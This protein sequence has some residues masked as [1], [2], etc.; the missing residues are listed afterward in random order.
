MESLKMVLKEP[1]CRQCRCREWTCRHSGGGRGWEERR[2]GVNACT[3]SGV[4]W[5]GGEQLLQSTGASLPLCDEMGEQE[6]REGNVCT[7]IAD[8]YCCMA[9][10]NTAL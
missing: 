5:R 2:G 6:G 4:R 9:E 10:S 8:V 1:V 7:V 3:L